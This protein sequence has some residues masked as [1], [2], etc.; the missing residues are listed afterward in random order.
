ME[1]SGNIGLVL[2][3]QSPSSEDFSGVN[4][5]EGCGLFRHF[6]IGE[7]SETSEGDSDLSR[8]DFNS[9]IYFSRG[10][11]GFSGLVLPAEA[12]FSA[13]VSASA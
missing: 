5:V 9:S 1:V 13:V 8:F 2:G 10:P 3:P 7:V 11:D 6:L 12:S 4:R